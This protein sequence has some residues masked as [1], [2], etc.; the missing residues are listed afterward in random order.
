VK[1]RPKPP[2]YAKKMH[3]KNIRFLIIP[4]LLAAA[5]PLFA[6]TAGYAFLGIYSEDISA[7]KARKLGSDNPFGSYVT[8]VIPHS[9]AEKAGVKMMD[10][11][12]GV[13]DF[14]TTQ[15]Q[16]LGD[17]F[18]KYRPNDRAVLH[19]IRKGKPRTL[20][21]VFGA[22]PETL[23]TTSQPTPNKCEDAF[24]GISDGGTHAGNGVKINIVPHSS[25]DEIGLKNGDILLTING[26]I[27]TDWSDIAMVIDHLRPGDNIAVR[28]TR[29]G[30]PVAASGILKSYAE[31]KKCPDCDCRTIPDP[32]VAWKEKANPGLRTSN[33]RFEIGEVPASDRPQLPQT[34]PFLSNNT[35]IINNLSIDLRGDKHAVVL[36][37][38]LPESGPVRV[39]IYNDSGRLIYDYDLGNFSGDFEDEVDLIQNTPGDFY[40]EIRQGTRSAL[41]KIRVQS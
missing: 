37:F 36:H 19:L 24:F 2:F 40:L 34:A 17:L 39:R 25:A 4:A 32:E 12:F 13:D 38:S 7:E 22:R 23:E 8:G 10:Y 20:R 18:R 26:Y 33:L 27:V 29:N 15:S 3:M 9:A 14:R 41:R 6:Q 5:A 30:Q 28:A 1:N 21:V 31:T 35:L 11:I 16:R